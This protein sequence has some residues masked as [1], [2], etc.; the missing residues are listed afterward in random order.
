[1]PLY[2]YECKAC[3]AVIEISKPASKSSEPETCPKCLGELER[4][5]MGQGSTFQLRGSGWTGNAL[6]KG[7]RK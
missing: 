2:D 6:T 3:E 5:F 1:M 7:R 4:V